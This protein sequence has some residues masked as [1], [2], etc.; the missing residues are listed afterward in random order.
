MAQKSTVFRLEVPVAKVW[1][2]VTESDEVKV[3]VAFCVTREPSEIPRDEGWRLLFDA[4]ARYAL[5]G[6]QFSEPVSWSAA[7]RE[8]ILGRSASQK[9]VAAAS[10]GARRWA[11][12]G[13]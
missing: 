9:Q 4:A 6:R 10:R 11:I 12:N 7:K 1:S 8:L 5:F 3:A 2:L 13:G